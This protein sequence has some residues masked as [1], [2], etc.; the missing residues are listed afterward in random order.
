MLEVMTPMGTMLS[1]PEHLAE[2]LPYF[3]GKGSP[4]A[5]EDACAFYNEHGYVVLRGLV[6]SHLCA[7]VRSIYATTARGC[8]VPMLRQRNMQYERNKFNSDGFLENPIFNIQDLGSRQLSVFR[9]AVLDILT[10]IEVADVVAALLEARQTKVIQSMFFEAPTGTWAHQDS[11]YQD[12]ASKLGM[13]VGGWFALEDIDANAGRFYVCPGSHK[14]ELLVRNEGDCNF[15]TGHD[16][17]RQTMLDRMREQA[18]DVAAPFLG[19]GDVLFWNSLTIHG[20]FTAGR[21]GLSRMSVTAHYL[22]DT[23]SMLQFHSRIRRQKNT[24]HNNMTVSL[25]HDQ[26]KLRNRLIRELAFRLPRTYFAARRIALRA[27]LACRSI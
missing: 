23:D 13:M 10:Q 18:V 7:H 27:V 20:S 19:A 21:S 9:K 17:Y 3:P 11:Y 2:D 16:C 12:S 4:G 8:R 14:S 24:K 25:L 6:S 15:A 5:I 1:V 22:D 26:D